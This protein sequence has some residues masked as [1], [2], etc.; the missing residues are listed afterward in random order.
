MLRTHTCGDLSSEH[1][2][3]SVTLCGW[4]DTARDHSGVLFVDLRDRYG[5]TQLVFRTDIEPAVKDIAESLRSEYVIKATGQV[6]KRDE[7]KINEKI[8]TG[9]I[10]V[11]VTELEV[12]NKSLTPPVSP[13]AQELPGED[14]RLKHRYLDLRRP[15]MQEVMQLRSRI[16]KIMRD[17]FDERGF[18]DVETPMLGR[19]TPEGARD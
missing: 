14:L 10:E 1:V 4:V 12:L 18:L 6:A 16:I 3:Q 2:G 11:Q 7:D 17:Y 15:P 9:E 13:S 8:A 19:S 5:K